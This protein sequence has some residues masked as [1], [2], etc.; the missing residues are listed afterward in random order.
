MM[1]LALVWAAFSTVSRADEACEQDFRELEPL[2]FAPLVE[3]R[4]LWNSP[5]PGWI[6]LSYEVGGLRLTH[7]APELSAP[8][9]F[10][11]LQWEV[12]DENNDVVLQGAN[13]DAPC[14]YMTLFA[15]QSTPMFKLP[16]PLHP[17][18]R[19][20]VWV[21]LAEAKPENITSE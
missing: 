13:I 16:R 7:R 8:A 17:S 15:G 5:S 1:G 12:L 14:G 9:S 10:R 2:L 6:E 21:R 11:D 19:L 3:G 18:E 20:R 4:A